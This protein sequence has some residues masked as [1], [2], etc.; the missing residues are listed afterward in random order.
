MARILVVKPSSLGDLIHTAPA[1]DYLSRLEPAPRISWIVRDSYVELVREFPG[2]EE[3][4]PFPRALFRASALLRRLPEAIRWIRG[5]RRGFDAAADFQRLQRSG[6]MARLSGAKDR[7]GFRDARELAWIHY[8]HRLSPPADSAH[9]VDRHLALACAVRDFLTE[10]GL[11][12]LPPSTPADAREWLAT[13]RLEVPQAYADFGARALG[14]G[15]PAVALCP[16]GRW[17]SKRWP[18]ERWAALAR[19]LWEGEPRLRPILVCGPSERAEA[20]RIAALVGNGVPLAAWVGRT[21]FWET[22]SLL[23]R[24]SAV[25]GVDSFPLHLAW[26]LGVPTVG[27]FGPSTPARIGPR[28]ERHAAILRE[29]LPCIGCWRHRCPLPE[30]L[31]MPG[32]SSDD[33]L[34]AIR[35]VRA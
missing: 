4:I 35:R 19:A 17:D 3:V 30:W 13:W 28:G 34:Q 12:R 10:R 26:A 23:S 18:A 24:A 20:E 8:N 27:L 9:E 6:L 16:S 7:F 2:V 29:D 33:V 5:L 21:G 1:V 15:P 25:V 11:A 31:C 14:E 32:I 22:A